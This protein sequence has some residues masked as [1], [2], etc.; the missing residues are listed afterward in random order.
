MSFYSISLCRV[1]ISFAIH[2]STMLLVSEFPRL[3][4]YFINDFLSFSF[5]LSLPLSFE[6]KH[7]LFSL[8]S[9][10]FA[11]EHDVYNWYKSMCVYTQTHIMIFHFSFFH[12]IRIACDIDCVY[13][14]RSSSGEWTKLKVFRSTEQRP[15]KH[16]MN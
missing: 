13:V 7:I 12:R 11:G 16:W 5:F 6:G 15:M 2:Q 8:E 14:R 3:L 1:F 10:A 4:E 9:G